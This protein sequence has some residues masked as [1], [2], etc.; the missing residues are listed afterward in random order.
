MRSIMSAAAIASRSSTSGLVRIWLGGAV[1]Q[2]GTPHRRGR[3]KRTK[4]GFE[5]RLSFIGSS[6]DL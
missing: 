1:P 4:V 2:T 6:N 3:R 5:D